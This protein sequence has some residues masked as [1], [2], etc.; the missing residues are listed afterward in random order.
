LSSAARLTVSG[1][2]VVE[3]VVR[4]PGAR[5]NGPSGTVSRLKRHSSFA[6]SSSKV[7]WILAVTAFAGVWPRFLSEN[8]ADST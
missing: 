5:E 6:V 2:S 3:N 7:A 4:S 8:D 1:G